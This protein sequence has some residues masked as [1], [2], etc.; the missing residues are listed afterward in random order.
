MLYTIGMWKNYYAR[1]FY[2]QDYENR[3]VQRTFTQSNGVVKEVI[4]TPAHG[5]MESWYKTEEF[6]EWLIQIAQD[7]L[8]D[9]WDLN[10]HLQKF[11]ETKTRLL[12][13][14]H[15]AAEVGRSGGSA[16][17]L[18][19]SYDAMMNAYD[20]FILYLW[21]PWGIT[22]Y[23]D[24]WF[25]EQLRAAY[26]KEADSMYEVVAHSPKAI[27]MQQMIERVWQWRLGLNGG[28]RDPKE[29]ENIVAEFGYLAGYSATHSYWTADEI[30]HQ[31]GEEGREQKQLEEAQQARQKAA[32][33]MRALLARLH[34]ENPLLEKVAR[35]INEYVWLRTERIDLYK[36][37]IIDSSSWFRRV[38]ELF[39]LPFGASVHMTTAELRG[40][41]QD[42]PV[43]PLEELERRMSCGYVAHITAH[44]TT[45][46]SDPEEQKQFIAKYLGVQDWSTQTEVRGQVACK[47]IVRG[48][49]RVMFNTNEND[50]M[51]TGEVLIANMTHP[52]YMPA[53][54]KAAAIVTDE[55]GI[56]CHAA[57]I[58]RELKIPCVIGAQN[59]TRIFA[60]G[61]MVEVDADQGIVKKI[62]V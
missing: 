58:S 34:A 12:A 17:E 37:S 38:E 31:A 15:S 49:A 4:F 26:P 25:L 22:E 8:K 19:A 51:Q 54:R 36:Q 32:Q 24:K 41:L 5:K 11:A 9:D 39:G 2:L 27:Q 3:Q 47:G 46:I 6:G 35:V 50:A 30:E 16:K 60:T 1:P 14:S 42:G 57:V 53:I 45:V 43:V 18:L 59:A 7:V 13:A 61:D 28:R 10:E 33:D 55:G 62:L 21:L 52:D 48:R 20:G 29:M 44:G 40:A 56:V 23:L